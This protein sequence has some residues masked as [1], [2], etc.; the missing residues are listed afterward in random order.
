M[1]TVIFMILSIFLFFFSKSQRYLDN[2][3]PRF[4]IIS[5]SKVAQFFIFWP[6]VV[7]LGEKLSFG[8]LSLVNLENAIF[9]KNKG[10][11]K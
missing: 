10:N 8:H 9:A 2:I 4:L 1:D 5:G 3:D 11:L 6:S 7:F